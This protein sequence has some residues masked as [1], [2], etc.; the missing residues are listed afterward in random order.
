[1]PLGLWPVGGDEE[2]GLLWQDMLRSFLRALCLIYRRRCPFTMWL[3]LCQTFLRLVQ[4]TDRWILPV[5]HQLLDQLWQFSKQDD[6]NGDARM[7][8]AARLVNKAFVLCI[9]DRNANIGQSRK[10]GTYKV[11]GLLLRIYFAIGQLNLCQNALRAIEA[12]QLPDLSQYPAAHRVTY[13]YYIGRYHFVNE[14]YSQADPILFQAFSETHRDFFTAKR[15]ILHL[16]IPTRILVQGTIPSADLLQ[17]HRLSHQFYG[18]ALDCLRNGNVIKYHGLL[19]TFEHD[20]LMMGTF[21][22]WERLTLL[23]YRALVRQVWRLQGA[24]TRLLFS[25]IQIALSQADVDEIGCILAGLIDCGLVKGYLSQEKATLV[26]S[27]ANPFPSL[28]SC[29]LIKP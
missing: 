24:T 19:D 9:T 27:Q 25:P 23:S 15:K 17:R 14:R 7:E 11:A 5:L 22:I 18:E 6:S 13:L 16:L 29:N 20:L 4:S 8:E 10:W 21:T 12:S 2:E 26:L 1:M 3:G 28:S